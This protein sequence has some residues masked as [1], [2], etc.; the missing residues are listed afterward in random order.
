MYTTRL[1]QWERAGALLCYVYIHTYTLA[2]D[3]TTTVGGILV[4]ERSL[5]DECLFVVF[6]HWMF[7]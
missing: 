6:A 7:G 3:W 2:L 1:T 4:N 5:D